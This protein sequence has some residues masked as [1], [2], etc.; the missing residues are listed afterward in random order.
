[1]QLTKDAKTRPGLENWLVPGTKVKLVNYERLASPFESAG[2]T[3]PV[4]PGYIGTVIEVYPDR[5]VSTWIRFKLKDLP[6]WGF[7]PEGSD[8]TVI[9]EPLE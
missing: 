6:R 2:I 1:M 7:S 3:P 4:Y 9:W 8:G 5:E